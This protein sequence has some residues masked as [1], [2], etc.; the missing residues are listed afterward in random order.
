MSITP[1][2]NLLSKIRSRQM[3]DTLK[4]GKRSNDR[5]LLSYR[6]ITIEKDIIKKANG[7]ASIDL[8]NTKVLVGVKVEVGPPYP[9]TPNS[10][11]L[12]V[13]AEFVPL[14]HEQFEPGPP[15]ENSIEVARVVD[16]SIRESQA[17]DVEK[18]VIVPNETV[19]VIFVDIYVLNHA[20]NL[21]GASEL[22][23]VSAL[24]NTK[25]PK[26]RVTEEGKVE[27]TSE[28]MP[29]P[30]RHVPIITTVAKIEDVIAV[31]PDIEEEQ[32][33]QTWVAMTITEE[34]KLCAIQKSGSGTLTLEE[35]SRILKISKEKSAELR[36]KFFK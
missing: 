35:I 3:V 4:S 21:V 10:G 17:L 24:L 16:R 6:Q 32:I 34:D 31:D 23:A 25:I 12:T 9:D 22:A 5:D 29:L 8:G 13:N 11:V 33:A 15:D 14:A 28:Y 1:Q 7:S 19:Y 18:L 27:K 30:M 20:G 2:T 26:Y 36:E